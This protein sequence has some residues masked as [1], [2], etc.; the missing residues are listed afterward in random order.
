MA[1]PHQWDVFISHASE[2]K[3]SVARPL[4]TLLEQAGLKVWLDENELTLGD[5]LS[6]KIDEGLSRSLYGVVILSP[7]FFSKD[8]PQRE[9]AGLAAKQRRGEKLILPVWH[10]VDHTFIGRYS[11][12]LADVVGVKTEEGLEKVAQ[13]VMCA[14]NQAR[15]ETVPQGVTV[16]QTAAI[17][18]K[19]PI[20]TMHLAAGDRFLAAGD[21]DKALEEYAKARELEPTNTVV[22]LRIPRAILYDAWH[23]SYVP[24]LLGQSALID[25]GSLVDRGLEAIYQAQAVDPSLENDLL[26]LLE[27][28]YLRRLLRKPWA[29]RTFLDQCLQRYPDEPD[30]LAEAGLFRCMTAS[31]PSEGTELV[32]RAIRARPEEPRLHYYLGYE[33]EEYAHED[34]PAIEEYYQAA[35]LAVGREGWPGKFRAALQNIASILRRWST[36]KPQGVLHAGSSIPLPKRAQMLQERCDFDKPN[37]DAPE[38]VLLAILYHNLGNP[39]RAERAIQ[40][41]AIEP[42]SEKYV[43]ELSVLER[44]CPPQQLRTLHMVTGRSNPFGVRLF[45]TPDAL[46]AVGLDPIG[47]NAELELNGRKIISINGKK[48]AHVQSVVAALDG[49]KPG[50]I[51]RVECER[52]VVREAHFPAELPI[53]RQST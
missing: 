37:A 47:M 11:P 16:P 50:E 18:T 39:E 46:Q 41:A 15:T 2:D 32:S 23:F 53:V 36:D 45:P 17:R 33:L 12:T 3:K 5:S 25:P 6:R 35:T 1:D 29:T 44:M 52:G 20:A 9:L 31:D 13:A 51:V 19:S 38:L 27:E 7:S 8:W 30:F 10:G 40:W 43:A 21:Y 48:T 4:T 42:N 34:D 28:S 26:L 49:L 24:S 14:I 22:L